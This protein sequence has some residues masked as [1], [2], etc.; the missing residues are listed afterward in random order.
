MHTL[1]LS[2]FLMAEPTK[3]EAPK[4][5]P[6]EQITLL[7]L[8]LNEVVA[9]L[10]AAEA[11]IQRMNGVSSLADAWNKRGCMVESDPQSGL[12]RC[13]RDAPPEAK[14]VKPEPKK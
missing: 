5:T 10:S 4:V 13:R 8:Q 1:L 7:R 6:E 3:V 9:K 14:E 11:M 12:V 2:L